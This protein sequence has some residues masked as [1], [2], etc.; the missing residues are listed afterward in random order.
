MCQGFPRSILRYRTSSEGNRPSCTSTIGWY[1][2]LGPL[3]MQVSLAHQPQ[4][5]VETSI[6][7]SPM[8]SPIEAPRNKPWMQSVRREGSGDNVEIHSTSTVHGP[9]ERPSV[10]AS[11]CDRSISLARRTDLA[12]RELDGLARLRRG[13]DPHC[14]RGKCF[15]AGGVPTDVFCWRGRLRPTRPG[16]MGGFS[17]LQKVS[18]LPRQVRPW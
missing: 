12:S 13:V 10:S 18:R 1:S 8:A 15:D 11:G 16:R 3:A 6:E 14:G 7:L 4:L 2:S 5:L 9:C 17:E